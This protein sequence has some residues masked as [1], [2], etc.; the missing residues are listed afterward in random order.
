MT[1]ID[2]FG[3][4]NKMLGR[5]YSEKSELKV[6][7]KV[8][9]NDATIRQ[10]V[11]KLSQFNGSDNVSMSKNDRWKL[12]LSVSGMPQLFSMN[13]TLIAS[14]LS[15]INIRGLDYFNK[16]RLD[17]IISE[18]ELFSIYYMLSNLSKVPPEK[19]ALSGLKIDL[20][21]Y[22]YAIVDYLA[23]QVPTNEMRFVESDDDENY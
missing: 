10:V 3:G 15:I 20:H 7:W 21:R 1:E 6:Q 22:L 8:N 14:S 23:S 16:E 18:E 19:E 12:A 9:K 11:E 13:S 4:G 17:D 5:S 2:D